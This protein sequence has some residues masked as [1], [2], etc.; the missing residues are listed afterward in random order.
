VTAKTAKTRDNYMPRLVFYPEKRLLFIQKRFFTL[1]NE[2]C[3]PLAESLKRAIFAFWQLPESYL[4]AAYA[5]SLSKMTLRSIL[6]TLS[7]NALPR[8]QSHVCPS[9]QPSF[10]VVRCPL[11]PVIVLSR[12]P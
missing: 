11:S 3:P 9:L 6:L 10:T 2:K 12:G 4:R 8:L 7:K 1:K 5:L